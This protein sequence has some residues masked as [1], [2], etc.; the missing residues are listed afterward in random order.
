VESTE[1]NE[2]R[3]N[4]TL[5]VSG[6]DGTKKP[7]ADVLDKLLAKEPMSVRNILAKFE[8]EGWRFNTSS[9]YPSAVLRGFL[10]RQ[11]YS[12]AYEGTKTM[13]SPRKDSDLGSKTP[14][15]G[16][17][18]RTAWQAQRDD[19]AKS[20]AQI[21]HALSV[22]REPIS[23]AA[24]GEKLG[25]TNGVGIVPVLVSLHEY[26][27]VKKL[28]KGGETLWDPVPDKLK[29]YSTE[30]EVR[31]RARRPVLNGVNH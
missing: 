30:F 29:N 25:R 20:K 8:H 17:G 28:S 2:N 27:A 14:K 15:T 12:F 1:S 10:K 31:L 18:K 23:I 26:G 19:R 9:S 13:F 5:T 24:I 11:G 21:I 6:R 4:T 16:K 3:Y 7:L 22:T